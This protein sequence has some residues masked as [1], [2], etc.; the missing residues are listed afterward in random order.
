M[1]LMKK[2]LL[3]LAVLSAA[4]KHSSGETGDKKHD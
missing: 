3:I 4:H 2:E 1:P